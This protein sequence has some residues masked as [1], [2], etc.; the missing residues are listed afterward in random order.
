MRGLRRVGLP[1]AVF[2]TVMVI[3]FVWLGATA[4]PCDVQ[5]SGLLLGRAQRQT[6]WHR[7]VRSEGY[8]TGYTY[9]L[10][11]G[12]AAVAF[13]NYRE[14]RFCSGGAAVVGGVTLSG[15]LAFAGCF[16]V[17]CCGSPMLGVYLSLFG[18][19]FLPFAKPLVAGITTVMI[20][21]FY[22]W[23]KRRVRRQTEAGAACAC[24]PAPMTLPGT[25]RSDAVTGS[26]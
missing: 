22:F 2:A 7:Y 1:L 17:G 11:L 3:H 8:W 5:D 26:S 13:R 10:S 6:W 19:E 9:A 25:G 4:G 24:G 12:F 20:S 15:F 21:F 18:A 16:L 23:M 14:R